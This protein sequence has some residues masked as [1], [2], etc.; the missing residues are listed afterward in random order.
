MT[1]IFVAGES[2]HPGDY[3][4]SPDGRYTLV[5]QNDGNLVL[6]GQN[7]QP[8]WASSTEGHQVTEAR[9]QDDGN[10]VL[11]D[12]AGHAA[13]ASNT[14]GPTRVGLRLVLQNDGNAVI[15]EENGRPVWATSTTESSSPTAGAT[16]R[17]LS[18]TK[19]TS[20][21][22]EGHGIPWYYRVLIILAIVT[23]LAS[24]FVALYSTS[25]NVLWL[26]L[27][28][29]TL[30]CTAATLFLV[31]I[32]FRWYRKRYSWF[33][34]FGSV[35]LLLFLVLNY[36]HKPNAA[37][38]DHQ[39]TFSNPLPPTDTAPAPTQPTATKTSTPNATVSSSPASSDLAL[40]LVANGSSVAYTSEL[41]YSVNIVNNGPET[42][43]EIEL[44]LTVSPDARLDTTSN[45][46]R[47]TSQGNLV[48][49]SILELKVNEPLR[50]VFIV[51]PTGF[52]GNHNY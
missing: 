40:T 3:L 43:R 38:S 42:A 50:L 20:P 1:E 41:T 30:G 33:I 36:G 22:G 25:E 7:N 5:L 21:N 23:V 51:V 32:P 18:T 9:L 11:Y 15:Y 8:R 27:T 37:N 12:A 6:Y 26:V 49:C 24:T 39:P 13:W 52:L 16:S 29:L 48:T 31:P 44:A 34:L 28:A 14:P 10:L 46:G 45:N 17:I 35:M 2:L 47:C 4:T 19:P